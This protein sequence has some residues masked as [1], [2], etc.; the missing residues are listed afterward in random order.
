MTLQKQNLKIWKS[1]SYTIEEPWW[2]VTLT[3]LA[4]IS[5]FAILFRFFCS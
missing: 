2:Q 4:T 1:N 3:G 5:P